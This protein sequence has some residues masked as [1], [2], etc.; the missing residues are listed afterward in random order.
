MLDTDAVAF[1]AA[2][3][4]ALALHELHAPTTTQARRVDLQALLHRER[5]TAAA[6]AAL[7]GIWRKVLSSSKD[8]LLLW[9]ALSTCEMYLKVDATV[10]PVGAVA[11]IGSCEKTGATT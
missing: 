3:A 6:D 2:S 7:R 8:E 9:F 5:A 11:A 4:T 1:A 10:S